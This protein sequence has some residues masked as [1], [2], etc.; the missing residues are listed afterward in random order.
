MFIE[1][2][3]KLIRDIIQEVINETEKNQPI[4]AT[5]TARLILVELN[6][7]RNAGITEVQIK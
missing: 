7:L 1:K 5:D 2:E 6:K 4:G 3:V